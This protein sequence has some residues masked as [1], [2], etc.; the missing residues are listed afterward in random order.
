MAEGKG[1]GRGLEAGGRAQVARAGGGEK[2]PER[3]LLKYCG[4]LLVAALIIAR[5]AP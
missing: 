5:G 2:S 1:Q 3:V 4:E